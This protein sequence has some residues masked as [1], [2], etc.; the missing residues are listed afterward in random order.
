[1]KK[2]IIILFAIIS[3][4]MI[5]LD[6]CVSTKIANK[7]GVQLWG[8]NC[9]RC[10]NAPTMDQYSAA[11][12]DVIGTHMKLKAGIT[13]EEVTKIVAYLQGVGQ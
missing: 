1:M 8:E 3:S 11:H 9:G 4:G 6:G 5:L 13:D 2:I 10:H 12:W 7:S